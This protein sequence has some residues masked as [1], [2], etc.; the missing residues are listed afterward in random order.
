MPALTAALAPTLAQ[1]ELF[2]LQKNNSETTKNLGC[3][4]R[5]AFFVSKVLQSI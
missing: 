2:I 1:W 5:A 3:L 4:T